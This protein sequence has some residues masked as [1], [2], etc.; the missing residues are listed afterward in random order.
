[1]NQSARNDLLARQDGKPPTI[2]VASTY[3]LPDNF[4]T[5]TLEV[6]CFG[7]G[8]GSGSHLC[9]IE[10]GQGRKKNLPGA[11]MRAIQISI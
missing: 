4:Q 9:L 11:E 8:V 1:M 3:R 5:C 10:P 6:Q 7:D 2:S